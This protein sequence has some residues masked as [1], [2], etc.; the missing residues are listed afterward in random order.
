MRILIRVSKAAI[1]ARRLGSLALPLVVLPVILHHLG[2]LD[3]PAFF[4]AALLAGGVSALAVLVALIALVRL[5][6]SGDHGWGKALSGLFL[7]LVCLV[8]F[9]WFGALAWRYPPV[10][11]IATTTRGDLPLIFAPDTA[12]MPP[13]KTL[14]AADQARIFP[15]ATTR[16]YPLD[17]AQLFALVEQ[18]SAERGWS[19]RLRRAP[20]EVGAD[21]RLN[22]RITTLA[23]WREEAVFRVSPTPE[24]AAVDMRSASINA[25]HDFG[26]NGERI[27]QFMVALDTAVTTLLRDNPSVN[28][29]EEEALEETGD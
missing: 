18:L 16:R 13:P 23:G 14:G 22:L 10:T 24:G 26:S 28:L 20:G 11:D 7:G 9:A 8:P 21:G 15:N 1:W 12:H 25:P 2:Y 5:W 19:V 17:T 4:L 3:S 29:P 6:Y 27:S